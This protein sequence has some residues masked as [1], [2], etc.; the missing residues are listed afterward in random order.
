MSTTNILDLNNRIDELADSYPADKVMMSDGVT[1]VEDRLDAANIDSAVDLS[2]YTSSSNVYTCPSDGYARISG[3]ASNTAT[4]YLMNK[5]FTFPY[6][7]LQT[8]VAYSS[9]FMRKG[10]KIYVTN[11]NSAVFLPLS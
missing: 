2:S 4:L 5:A 8:N 1:S 10:V 9:I 7:F 11:A 3:T 6:T